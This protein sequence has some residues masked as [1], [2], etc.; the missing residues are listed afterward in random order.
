[1]YSDIRSD[2]IPEPKEEELNLPV[3]ELY[4]FK[5]ETGMGY[6]FPNSYKIWVAGDVMFNWG[7]R[8]SMKAEDPLF[9]FRSFSFFLQNYDYRMLNLETPILKKTP[10]ADSIKSYIFYGER[11]DLNLL[12]FLGIDAV[13]L[14][15]NHTMD[16]GEAGL[17]D[18]LS[19]LDE[20]KISY[21]GAGLNEAESLK[22]ILIQKDGM[23]YRVFSFSD[24]GETRLFSGSKTP[25]AA[26][27]RVGTA[28]K[29]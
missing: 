1:M 25:G 13:F 14:G 3:S 8:D 12:K 21:A 18:T 11:K 20:F 23:E 2:R 26:Y 24:T 4:R 5:T 29:L 9:A 16:F 6:R 22:P 27:F 10:N 19:L 15:N 17:K 7:V 28:E